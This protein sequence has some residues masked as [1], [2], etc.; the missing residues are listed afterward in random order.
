[1]KHIC[2]K[3]QVKFLKPKLNNFSSPGGSLFFVFFKK[4][5]GAVFTLLLKTFFETFIVLKEV[6]Y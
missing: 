6:N 2:Q 5:S 3:N 4:I 1:M